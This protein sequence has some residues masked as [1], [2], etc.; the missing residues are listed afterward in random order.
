M[1]KVPAEN[2]V[3]SPDSVPVVTTD[4]V[5]DLHNRIV[6]LG[7]AW[8]EFALANQG[9]RAT[10]RFVLGQSLE[11]FIS[12]DATR[13]F[14]RT[15]LDNVR[16][17]HYPLT[18]PYRCD[19]PNLRRHLEMTLTPLGSGLVR[20]E[21]RVLQEIPVQSV[22]TVNSQMLQGRLQGKDPR[23]RFIHRCSMC[24]RYAFN[25]QWMELAELQNS[26]ELQAAGEIPVIHTVCPE[27][28]DNLLQRRR[29]ST[30]HA[31][32]YKVLPKRF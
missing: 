2:T 24:C 4:Y 5:L 10:R 31:E 8:D 25:Q 21:H 15:L 26:P 9:E 12:G 30:L 16:R 22:F 3:A 7:G 18:R 11:H 6:E 32:A 1:T 29:R 23:Y 13:M 17:L 28:K 14:L 27:C 20:L 19:S